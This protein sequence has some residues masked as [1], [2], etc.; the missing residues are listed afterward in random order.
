M[1]KVVFQ[2]NGNNITIQC[3][4]QQ[5]MSE[6]CKRFCIKANIIIEEYLFL[7]NGNLINM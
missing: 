5:A 2:L 3:T 4:S 1:S 6:I 7:Y